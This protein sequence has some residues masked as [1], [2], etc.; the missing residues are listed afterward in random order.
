MRPG[1]L[2]L[3]LLLW[4]LVSGASGAPGPLRLTA[5]FDRAYPPYEFLED[6]VPGGFTVD[7]LREVAREA[8][9][10]VRFRSGPW[11][12]VFRDLREGRVDLLCGVFERSRRG[13]LIFSS[14]H[15]DLDFALYVRRNSPARSLEDLEGGSVLVQRG[16]IMDEFAQERIPRAR[17]LEVPDL[18]DTLR[19]LAAGEGDGALLSRLQGRYLLDREGL[20]GIREIPLE[21]VRRGYGFAVP[22]G[23]EDLVVLL[24]EGLRRARESGA[25]DR[26]Y[27]KWFGPLERPT[28]EERVRPAWPF[29][30][31][32]LLLA[33]GAMLGVWLLHR[34]VRGRMA[35][36]RQVIDLVPHFIY[37]KDAQGRYL[38]A[39]RATAAAYGRSVEDLEGR[40]QKEVHPDPAEADRFVRDDR[41]VLETGQVFAEEERF[42]PREE[43]EEMRLLTVKVP[44]VGRTRKGTLGIS[45]DL[46]RQMR[47]EERARDLVEE[48]TA[49]NEALDRFAAAASH[50]L[51]GPLVTL[52]SFVGSLRRDL[53]SGRTDRLEG[54]LQRVAQAAE[55]MG[56]LLEGMTRLAQVGRRQA[57]R[58]RVDLGRVAREA[59]D[60][61][62]ASFAQTGAVLRVAPAL[63]EVWGD[64]DALREVFLNLFDN[65]LKY[66]RPEEPPQI[67]VGALDLGGETVVEVEDRG[68]GLD[69]RQ[70]EQIFGLFHKLDPQAPGM[71]LGLAL[72]RRIVE[73]HR[74]RIWVESQ[75]PGTGAV[76][77]FTLPG[78]GETDREG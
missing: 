58:E 42:R 39:N 64:P 60:L 30:S 35:E 57:R 53:A 18:P 71:G 32:A 25:Y 37:V 6:G 55:T 34:Q 72:V 24:N 41:R 28:L 26:V 2:G 47:A 29:L 61:L 56:S 67:R 12:E 68:I 11:A 9:F 62:A 1:I 22:A 52:R 16:D 21:G 20:R 10:E 45:V 8:G 23:R 15:L 43:G 63:P 73:L 27:R 74:G 76:F 48:L 54:D 31:G 77:R 17:R 13:D 14:P 78:L 3:L 38:L 7:L 46:T 66:A 65:A 70:G 49:K 40:T 33:V 50:D 44:F 51:R 5:G 19:R 4:G 75:G 59:R 69:P 36:L